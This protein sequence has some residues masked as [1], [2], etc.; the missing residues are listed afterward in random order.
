MHICCCNAWLV[1]IKSSFK[2][3]FPYN[4]ILMMMI[5][6]SLLCLHNTLNLLIGIYA[7]Y[8]KMI[9]LNECPNLFIRGGLF[10]VWV[11]CERKHHPANSAFK[12]NRRMAVFPMII[13]IILCTMAFNVYSYSHEC[14]PNSRSAYYQMLKKAFMF[15]SWLYVWC[16]IFKGGMDRLNVDCPVNLPIILLFNPF[17]YIIKNLYI[18]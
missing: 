5:L 6:L 17:L 2:E 4:W 9:Q 15:T 8:D 1:I 3:S 12:Q 7:N 18:G 14:I 10:A 13:I 11:F 16:A